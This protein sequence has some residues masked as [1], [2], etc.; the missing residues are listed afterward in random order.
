MP[1]SNLLLVFVACA[2]AV[3][4]AL[5]L[6]GQSFE[7]DFNG[8]S[9]DGV[10]GREAGGAVPAARVGSSGRESAQRAGSGPVHG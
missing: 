10:C 6:M 1:R 4:V 2:I 3:Y 8:V 5:T 7:S 9:Y